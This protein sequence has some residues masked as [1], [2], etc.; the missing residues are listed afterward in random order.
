MQEL[1]N[2]VVNDF[3]KLKER[4]EKDKRLFNLVVGVL[5]EWI[6]DKSASSHVLYIK[7]VMLLGREAGRLVYNL[8]TMSPGSATVLLELLAE[9]YG[10]SDEALV[11]L[12][13]LVARM[14]YPVYVKT[15]KMKNPYRV[16]W[17]DADV[18]KGEEKS[19]EMLI[20]VTAALFNGDNVI[21]ELDEDDVK[22]LLRK[23]AKNNKAILINILEEIEAEP[24]ENNSHATKSSSGEIKSILFM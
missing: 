12:R 15:M 5:N 22:E 7:L 18:L 24:I 1:S 9:K 14:H 11:G 16:I 20:R 4:Y 23:I 8:L 21:L 2:I 6:D 13:D 10:D 19:E 17:I 3:E